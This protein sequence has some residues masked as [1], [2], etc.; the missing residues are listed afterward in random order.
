MPS[1]TFTRRLVDQMIWANED[2]ISE[3]SR[4]S[5]GIVNYSIS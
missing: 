3:G 1:R 2:A 5:F 4:D